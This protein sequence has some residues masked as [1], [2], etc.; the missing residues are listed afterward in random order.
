MQRLEHLNA[1]YTS[2]A[3]DRT[4]CIYTP[5]KSIT[6]LMLLFNYRTAN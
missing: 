1:P 4:R 5:V 3:S 2:S 6:R